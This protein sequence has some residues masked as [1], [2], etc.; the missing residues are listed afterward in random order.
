MSNAFNNGNK[1]KG[2][3]RRVEALVS[4][5]AVR[6]QWHVDATITCPHCEHENNFMDIDEWWAFSRIG[7]NNK[8][9]IYPI[10]F[11]CDSCGKTFKVDGSD[12]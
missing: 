8:N 4:P 1:K 12:Y 11:E 3:S 9:F 5:Q 7:E 2:S 10:D 6:V